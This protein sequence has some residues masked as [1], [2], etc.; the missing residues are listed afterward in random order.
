M[1]RRRFLLASGAL[2]AAPFAAAQKPAAANKVLG[3]LSG[4]RTPTPQQIAASPIMA[5]LRELGWIE[6]KNLRIE[7]A[8]GEGSE[9]RLPALAAE[10][11]QKRVDVIWASG[12]E[13]AV[14][15]A[16]ATKTLP[17]VFTGVPD[18]VGQGLVDSLARPGRNLTGVSF[19]A[20]GG[21]LAQKRLELLKEAVPAARRVALIR[22]GATR[23]VAGD[24]PSLAPFYAAA[25]KLGIEL[26]D[27]TVERQ[28]DFGAVFKKMLSARAQAMSM[29]NAALTLREL[30][31]ILDFANRNRI[32]AIYGGR[33]WVEAGGLI[34]YGTDIQSM[35]RESLAYVDR[36]LRGAKPADLPVLQPTRFE[37]A[38]NLQTAKS[39]GLVIPQTIL[40]RAEHVIK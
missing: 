23:T 39:L 20:A 12:P 7:R 33:A 15:A 14:A 22:A 19:T 18:P 37:L 25:K 4:N 3:I 34:S 26:Q 6:G 8:Y 35:T 28:E 30:K 13:A 38:V 5:R 10:L 11:V 16:N 32:P 1:Q 40:L 36:I 9:D 29:A 17:I 2:I 24:F 21:E 27:Y 31:Q